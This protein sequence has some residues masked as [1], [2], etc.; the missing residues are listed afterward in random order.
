MCATIAVCKVWLGLSVIL[1]SVVGLNSMNDRL[2]V[3]QI[4]VLHVR[5]S[6]PSTVMCEV[7]MLFKC[8]EACVVV[9]YRVLGMCRG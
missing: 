6:L 9:E 1:G 4:V 7:W 8:E 3:F 2:D 5:L